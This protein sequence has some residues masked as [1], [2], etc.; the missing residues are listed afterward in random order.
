MKWFLLLTTADIE[1]GV[2]EK[3]PTASPPAHH[4]H[5][6]TCQRQDWD[7]WRL[8][9]FQ[10]VLPHGLSALWQYLPTDLP[11]NLSW[12]PFCPK[13]CL[14]HSECVTSICYRG[15]IHLLK[16]GGTIIHLWLMHM[17]NTNMAWEKIQA[18]SLIFLYFNTLTHLSLKI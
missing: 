8:D 15:F 9:I 4:H 18:G 5:L 1:A 17:T 13:Q 12:A 3:P 10:N 14:I 7:G 2:K 6:C 11:L 16:N